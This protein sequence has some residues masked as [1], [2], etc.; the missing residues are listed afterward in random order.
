MKKLISP[1]FGAK[2]LF[3]FLI[4]YFSFSF[5]DT[6]FSSINM[7]KTICTIKSQH[8][9]LF[10]LVINLKEDYNS[11]IISIP[12]GFLLSIKNDDSI[13][14]VRTYILRDLIAIKYLFYYNLSYIGTISFSMIVFIYIH[15]L[16]KRKSRY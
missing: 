3:A 13:D 5:F 12:M 16:K 10:S 8:L 9:S 2:V 1:L 4:L 14:V 11:K 7:R 6:T 15:F